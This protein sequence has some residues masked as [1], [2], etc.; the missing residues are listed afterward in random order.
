MEDHG[1]RVEE[2]PGRIAFRKVKAPAAFRGDDRTEFG[3][4]RQAHRV[5]GVDRPSD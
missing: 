1:K 5:L 4:V 3:A 2:G